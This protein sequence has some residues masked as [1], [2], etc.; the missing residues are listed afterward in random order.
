M[1]GRMFII[2]S[3][4]FEPDRYK[5]LE[6]YFKEN[7]PNIQIEYF[8]PYYKNR[9]ED[10]INMSKYKNQKIGEIMLTETYIK[11]FNHIIENNIKYVVTHESDVIFK[12]NYFDNLNKLFNE[13]IISAKH[14]SVVFF[15]TGCG[16]KPLVSNKISENL[17]IQNATHCVDSMI[18]D[19][20]AVKYILKKMND[21]TTIMSPVDH[22]WNNYF[23]TDI[24][25]YWPGTPIT[26]QGSIIGKYK[27][28][29]IS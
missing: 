10:K 27:S 13:W 18:F 24:F 15:S 17:Y 1:I 4:E 12:D 29:R 16:F 19:I 21:T 14:P 9:D 6:K 23:G 5:Y 22:L 26:H 3:K 8:E 20:E 11:L 25:G 28:H 7:E 2:I